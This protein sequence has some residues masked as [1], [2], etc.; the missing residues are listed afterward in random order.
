[1]LETS[2]EYELGTI[3][4]DSSNLLVNYLLKFDR[5]DGRVSESET[6][7]EGAKDHVVIN[8]N[9]NQIVKSACALHQIRMFMLNGKFDHEV[10]NRKKW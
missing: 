3:A 8:A 2:I 4:G 1:M 5:N 6:I 10:K 7:V 9:H